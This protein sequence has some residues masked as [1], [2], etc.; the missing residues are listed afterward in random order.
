MVETRI[1]STLLA[2]I[3]HHDWFVGLAFIRWHSK[4]IEIFSVCVYFGILCMYICL[5]DVQGEVGC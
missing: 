2:M 1:L 4:F 3:L 5:F